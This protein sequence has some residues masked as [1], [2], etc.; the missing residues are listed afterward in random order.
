MLLSTFVPMLGLWLSISTSAVASPN[1]QFHRLE[2]P[3][4]QSQNGGLEPAKSSPRLGSQCN[5]HTSAEERA[6]EN[7]S[8]RRMRSSHRAGEW[9]DVTIPVHF[10]ILASNETE[11]GGWL[12]DEQIEAQMQ[13]LND[14]FAAV[15]INWELVNVT[16][17]INERWFHGLGD[18]PVEKMWLEV[19]KELR[20]GGIDVLN[21]YT[22]EHA[23]GLGYASMPSFF[24]GT[25]ESLTS[26]GIV[27]NAYTLPG[28]R[29]APY[30]GG[31]T[32][33]HEAGHWA[34]LHHT[35]VEEEDRVKEGCDGNGD[36]VDDT[37][38]QLEPTYDCQQ[39]DTCAEQEG[40]D[41]INNFMD[42]SFDT[43]L[44]EFTPGQIERMRQEI[45][46]YREIE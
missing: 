5:L 37:P 13:V 15:Q 29:Y 12:P 44:Q 31:R 33:T 8:L 36:Y 11:A 14:D 43:C 24:D 21:I 42:Y 45:A 26:D 25:V 3:S 28:G 7:K 20:V 1:F 9:S 27:I 40:L 6:E 10:H 46:T 16:R 19:G 39:R 22:S 32:L 17:I 35:F 2:R 30:N 38:A 18:K 34:G 4:G 41:P 23:E